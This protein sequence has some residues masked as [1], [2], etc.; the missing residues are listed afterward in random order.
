MPSFYHEVIKAKLQTAIQQALSQAGALE[1]LNDL[2]A[3]G[4]LDAASNMRRGI[5]NGGWCQQWN[6]E[7]VAALKRKGAVPPLET[8]VAE[9]GTSQTLEDM[10]KVKLKCFER[11]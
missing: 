9:V 6:D 2:Q 1:G 3:V 8:L 7:E 4:P 5:S 10:E 11:S